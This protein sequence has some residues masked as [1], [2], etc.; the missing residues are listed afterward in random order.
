MTG[1]KNFKGQIWFFLYSQKQQVSLCLQ[2]WTSVS[3]GNDQ[4]I[5]IFNVFRWVPSRKNIFL[6]PS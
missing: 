1:D 6:G 2:R 4:L 3:F 5:I